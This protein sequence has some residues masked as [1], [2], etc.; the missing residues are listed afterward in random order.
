[1]REPRRELGRVVRAEHAVARLKVGGE[2]VAVPEVV[3]EPGEGGGFAARE[4]HHASRVRRLP[5]GRLAQPNLWQRRQRRAAERRRR[6]QRVGGRQRQVS[7]AR[8]LERRPHLA[9][10]L[11]LVAEGREAVRQVG[12]ILPVGQLAPVI[13][14]AAPHGLELAAPRRQRRAERAVHPKLLGR[15]LLLAEDRRMRVALAARSD[16][17]RQQLLRLAHTDEQVAA[18]AAQLLAQV[19]DGLVQELGAEG[20][21]LVAAARRA[22]VLPRVKQKDRQHLRLALVREDAGEARVVV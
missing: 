7:V 21:R 10:A 4:R 11:H 9:P 15:D 17:P 14:R 18:D 8:S 3:L 19:E 2:G 1:M 13:Q 6:R 5:E 12:E 16:Q 20:A 22:P